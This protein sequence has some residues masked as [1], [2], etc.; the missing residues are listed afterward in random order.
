MP[1]I[2]S[3][4]SHYLLAQVT[5]YPERTL[6]LVYPPPHPDEMAFNCLKHYKG[7]CLIYVGEGRNGVNANKD[8]F[9]EIDQNWQAEIILPSSALEPF[10]RGYE[11]LYIFRRTKNKRS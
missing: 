3:T 11:R 5:Q 4:I 7:A 8:F 9:D 1:V 6:L 2:R 10:P